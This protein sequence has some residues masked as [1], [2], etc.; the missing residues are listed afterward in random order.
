MSEPSKA[1]QSTWEGF[2]RPSPV[3]LFAMH[4]LDQTFGDTMPDDFA[5]STDAPATPPTDLVE[6]TKKV[7]EQLAEKEEQVATPGPVDREYAP[8]PQEAGFVVAT[9]DRDSI[10][11]PE[12]ATQY[13]PEAKLKG[14]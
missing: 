8:S 9:H 11:P 10:Q 6:E 12:K 13:A 7:E 14:E 3:E 1:P 4:L 5:P 2:N